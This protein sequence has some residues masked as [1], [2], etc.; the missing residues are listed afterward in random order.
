MEFKLSRKHY[1]TFKENKS[2]LK[3]KYRQDPNTNSIYIRIEWNLLQKFGTVKQK[4]FWDNFRRKYINSLLNKYCTTSKNCFYT[5]IGS[6]SI[7]SD[8]DINISGEDSV[9]IIKSIYKEHGKNFDKSLE[10]LFDVN[11]YGTIFHYLDKIRDCINNPSKDECFPKVVANYQQRCWSF[12]RIVETVLTYKDEDKMDI[13][14]FLPESYRKL[15]YDSYK[16]IKKVKNKYTGKDDYLFLLKKYISSLH[17]N[18]KNEN[19]KKLMNKYSTCKLF[20]N[21]SYRSAGAVLHI[22]YDKKISKDLYYDS[23]Y[24]NLGFIFEISNNKFNILKISKYIDRI[25]DAMNK[26]NNHKSSHKDVQNLKEI[27]SKLN[28]YRKLKNRPSLKIKKQTEKLYELL[29]INF[30]NKKVNKIDFLKKIFNFILN[31][32][33]KD[34]IIF[35]I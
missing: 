31:N 23:I 12:S 7:F 25:I 30:K 20:E 8:I 29:N 27:V 14:N 21:E 18:P 9:Y 16:L 2:K 34:K 35:N 1:E 26:I 22:V 10:V 11:I 24:D 32:I 33:P 15:F 5:F 3:N 19:P 13:F 4:T 17:K 6:N 28:T